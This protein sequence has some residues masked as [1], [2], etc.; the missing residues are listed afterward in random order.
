MKWQ[1][2]NNPIIDNLTDFKNNFLK[3]RNISGELE[4][5]FWQFRDPTVYQL[6]KLGFSNKNL[7]KASL[8]LEQAI[9]NEEKI[10][11]YG[12]YDADGITATA[13][14]WLVLKNL[15]LIAQPFIPHRVDDGY[16]MTKESLEKILKEKEIDLVISVD[17][18][19][20]AFQAAQFLKE[21]NI[22]LIITDHHQFQVVEDKK[23]KPPCLACVHSSEVCGAMVAW[24]FMNYFFDFLK[25]EDKEIIDEVFILAGLATL[26]D[27]MPLLGINRQIVKKMLTQIENSKN[28]GLKSLVRKLKLDLKDIGVREANYKIIPCLNAAGRIDHGKQALRLLCSQNEQLIEELSQKLKDINFNRKELTNELWKEALQSA[29]QQLDKKYLFIVSKNF[30]EGVVGLLA[31]R[32][33]EKFNLITFVGTIKDEQIK[34][35]A[36]CLE[37]IDLMKILE[38]IR[39]DCLSLGGHRGAAGFSFKKENLA[40]I[41]AKLDLA[42]KKINAFE[43]NIIIESR[44]D[45][46]LFDF[47]FLDLLKKL[48][49]FGKANQELV[50]ATKVKVLDVRFLGAE[51]KHAKLLVSHYDNTQ[52]KA[53][54][55]INVLFWNIDKTDSYSQILNKNI[56]LVF[57]PGINKFNHK[58]SLQFIGLDFKKC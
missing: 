42:T 18:G 57:K 50:L 22:D 43:K 12:D 41:L 28:L 55:K 2:L 56:E 14:I 17:N 21:K 51:K 34:V 1:Y 26:A 15:G 30:H 37:N 20:V 25:K 27:Q 11:I 45:F 49:P 19:S 29:R 48:S 40:T 58:E 3:L 38:N 6:E 23:I 7:K 36:R 10:L 31:S 33:I 39:K 4:E 35:S 52:E 24:F 8:R 53:Y 9:K 5:D 46:K 32:L 44:L 16:G 47:E 13:I 54:Q